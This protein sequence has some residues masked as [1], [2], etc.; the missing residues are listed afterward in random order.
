MIRAAGIDD[1][2]A[3]LA[4]EEA[5]FG[6]EAWAE[7]ALRAELEGPRRRVL[8]Y[9]TPGG[10]GG[11]AVTIT[12]GAVADLAR[13][14]VPVE[15]RREGVARALL[16]RLLEASATDGAEAMMLE[17]SVTNA[18]ARRLY[19]AAGFRE[20]DRRAGYYRDGSDAVVLRRELEEATA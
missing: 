1:L 5:C 8:V 20:I 15:R 4:L 6:D 13:I 17:V 11:Y 18:A 12:A 7:K 10:L 9:D 2:P 3:L 19:A 14:A 16:D